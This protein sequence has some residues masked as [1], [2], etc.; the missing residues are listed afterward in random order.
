M[1]LRLGHRLVVQ[2]LDSVLLH[3]EAKQ[4]RAEVRNAVKI[5]WQNITS[6]ETTETKT[7][8]LGQRGDI[9][10]SLKTIFMQLRPIDSASQV[11]D[12]IN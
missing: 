4:A 2:K 11:K 9:C 3:L 6:W 8:E 5:V 1:E 10:N 12:L 7:K